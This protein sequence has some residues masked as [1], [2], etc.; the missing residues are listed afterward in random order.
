MKNTWNIIDGKL[1]KEFTLKDFSAC[2]AF[3]QKIHPLAEKMNHHPDMFLHSYKKVKII[4]FTHS[5]NKITDL[6]YSLA[7]QIDKI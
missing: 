2:I 6:D 5:L 4:L 7:K 3:M 1:V